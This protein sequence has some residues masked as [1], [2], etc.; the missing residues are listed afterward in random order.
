M[1]LHNYESPYLLG[2][3]KTNKKVSQDFKNMLSQNYGIQSQDF[4]VSSH[5]S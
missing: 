3:K 5:N 4:D 1:T 2:K